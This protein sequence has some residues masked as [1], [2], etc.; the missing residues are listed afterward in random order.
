V[1]SRTFTQLSFIGAALFFA[2]PMLLVGAAWLLPSASGYLSQMATQGLLWE[3]GLISIR[4]AVLTAAITALLAI[5][6]A[7]WVSMYHLPLRC[8]LE[9]A[10]VLPLAIPPYIAAMTY[11]GLLEGAGAVQYWIRETF[12]LA[13]GEYWFPAIRSEGGMIFVLTLTLYPYV[14]LLAR[15]AF[16]MQSRHMLETATLLGYGRVSLFTRVALPTARPAWVAGIALVVMEVLADFGVA[17]LYGVPV[18]TTGIYRAWQ[19]LYDPIAA[20]RLATLLLAVVFLALWAE[21]WARGDARFQNTTALYHPLERWFTSTARRW[22]MVAWCVALPVCGFVLPAATLVTWSLPAWEASLV[23]RTW[24]VTLTS[25]WIA[26]LTASVTVV[27]GLLCAYAVRPAHVPAALRA[28]VGLL[29][30]GYAIPGSV[31]AVGVLV[32]FL[33]LEK[34]VFFGHAVLTGTILGVVWG[35]CL[36]FLT[37]GFQTL[38]SGLER[39]TPAM[40]EAAMMLGASPRRR[41]LAVHVPM[42]KGALL[43]AF[44]LVLIDTLKE[45]PITLMLRPFNAS[46]LAI[47]A[48]ELAKDGVMHLAA[49]LALLLVALSIP[50]VLLLSRHLRGARPSG[51]LDVRY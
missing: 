49:P 25:A 26:A 8:T 11:G 43:V 4:V 39:I 51:E 41:L 42:L 20:A 9:W 50:P 7:W 31:I 5:P 17:S 32:V 1:L 46:T 15:G 2:A 22:G 36:R 47:Q 27:V 33:T 10:L 40:D 19:S 18:F 44:L 34:Q 13:Y 35:C 24:E 14:Y 30:C 21:R 12:G 29:T 6:A 45:L 3:T 23:A 48:Y 38:R 37:I 16:L 28:V